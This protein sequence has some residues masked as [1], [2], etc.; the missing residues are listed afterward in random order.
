MN[1]LTIQINSLEA[2]ERLI[3]G[4]SETEVEVRNSVIQKFA[5]KHLK[6]LAN[7]DEI[8]QTLDKIQRDISKE[9]SI[10]CSREIA[11]FK[12][13]GWG[14]ITSVK[15]IDKVEREISSQVRIS[16]DTAIQKAVDEAVKVWA[17][18]NEIKKR[19]NSKFDY[20]TQ[21]FIKNEVRAKLEAVKAKL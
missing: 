14:K 15:L 6:A 19:I 5:D 7:T 16:A 20:Y 8:T 11:S 9:V 21:D 2:L 12:K 10:R 17:N 1:K 13:D 3:G 4:D 18:D